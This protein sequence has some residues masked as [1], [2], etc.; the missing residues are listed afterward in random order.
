[1]RDTVRRRR[2]C[3]L[4]DVADGH[5]RDLVDVAVEKT[6]DGLFRVRQV[7]VKILIDADEHRQPPFRFFTVFPWKHY[8]MDSPR[9]AVFSYGS[10]KFLF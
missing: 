4:G 6:D 9:I 3:L 8:S 1:M 5:G 10:Q 7:L 2:E